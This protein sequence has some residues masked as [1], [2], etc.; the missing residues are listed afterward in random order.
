VRVAAALLV[1]L[2]ALPAGAQR[3][4]PPNGILLVA[5]PGLTDPNF[6]ETV[7][8]VTQATDASTVGVILNRPAGRKHERTGEPLYAGGPVMPQVIVALFSA[9]DAPIASFQVLQNVY[10]S[11]HPRNV[12]ALPSRPGQRLRFFTGFSGWAPN[13]LQ[14]ELRLDAWFVL[15]VTEEI[16][17]RADTRE[18]WK[19]LFDKARGSRADGRIK[20]DILFS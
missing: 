16:L 3:A 8:L 5:K 17:F 15:P 18:M 9:D 11:M 20:P 7:V 1:L 10:L 14:R 13:Q 19:E 6:R 4:E 12:D 2:A